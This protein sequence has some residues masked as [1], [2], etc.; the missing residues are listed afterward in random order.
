M[1]LLSFLKPFMRNKETQISISSYSKKELHRL[2]NAYRLAINDNIISS[3]TDIK[4][5]IL[6]ANN[7]FCNVSKYT[8]KELVGQR[9]NLLVSGYHTKEFYKDL[10]KTIGKGN[11]WT[12]EIKNK[13]KDGNYFWVDTLIFPIKDESGKN[14]QY[15]SLQTLINDKKKAEQDRL[16]YLKSLE[17]I[18]YMTSHEVRKP[19]ANLIGLSDSIDFNSTTTEELEHL[20]NHIKKEAKELDEYTRKL[21]LFMHELKE[22]KL[23]K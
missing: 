10:W 19:I 16:E 15:L 3:I 23:L 4:G 8:S 12:G 9:H 6:Y 18:I 17:E 5:N 1:Y 7:Y 20:I 2:L 22:K 13:D 14:V 21:T 11:V